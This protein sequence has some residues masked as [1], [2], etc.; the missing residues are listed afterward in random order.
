MVTSSPE[1]DAAVG[2]YLR[3]IFSKETGWADFVKSRNGVIPVSDVIKYQYTYVQSKVERYVGMRV[4]MGSQPEAAV[5]VM[6]AKVHVLKAFNMTSAWGEDCSD[7]LHLT[8]LYGPRGRHCEDPQVV[9]MM[10]DMP[11]VTTGMYAKQYLAFL[12]DIHARW[13]AEHP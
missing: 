13:E 1:T 7:I 9:K 10:N 4:P 11:P 2:Q 6:I 3:S 5:G 12:R 8:S